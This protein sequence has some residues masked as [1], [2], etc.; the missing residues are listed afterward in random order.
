MKL[1]MIVPYS[2]DITYHKMIELLEEQA[3]KLGWRM[4]KTAHRPDG[5]QTEI[6]HIPNEYGTDKPNKD[7]STL[8]TFSVEVY[9]PHNRE[10]N[11][12]GVDPHAS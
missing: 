12:Y 7:G 4:M 2:E 9:V 1:K 11:N 5:F 3:R 8:L 6:I 10:N